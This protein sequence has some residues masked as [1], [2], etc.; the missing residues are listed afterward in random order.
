MDTVRKTKSTEEDELEE[1]R[2]ELEGL[3]EK[4]RGSSSKS[5][6]DDLKDL[7]DQIEKMEKAEKKED[8]ADAK[9]HD[10]MKAEMERLRERIK[11]LE[12]MEGDVTETIPEA[13]QE[14]SD[15]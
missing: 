10:E 5:D 8:K 9:S 15:T 13:D 6:D 11:E 2:K 1:M 3:R 14:S 4:L 12:S 7:L